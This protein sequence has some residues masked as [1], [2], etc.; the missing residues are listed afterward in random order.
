MFLLVAI[1]PNI[2]LVNTL[3]ALLVTPAQILLNCL[4]FAAQVPSLLPQAT[5]S[6]ISNALQSHRDASRVKLVKTTL[7]CA[8]L[9]ITALI[10]PWLL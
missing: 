1:K 10:L 2:M 6:D 4:R 3:L 5:A 9:S 7:R 8:H